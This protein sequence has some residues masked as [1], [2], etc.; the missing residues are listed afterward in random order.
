VPAQD[1]RAGMASLVIDEN[2]SISEFYQL[3]LDELPKYS[4]P[5]FLRI[6][7]EIETTGT[8]KYKKTD[9]VK[10]GFDP[11]TITDELYFADTL[12]NQYVKLDANLFQKI[13][14]QEVRI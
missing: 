2:F 1:G 3:L 13:H 9:L 5:V 10:D 12:T 4:I 14:N 11:N 8:F 6:S 7:P